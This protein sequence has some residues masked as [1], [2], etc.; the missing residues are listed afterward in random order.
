MQIPFR[1][2]RTFACFRLALFC[3]EMVRAALIVEL[4]VPTIGLSDA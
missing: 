2:K 4:G 3:T 1:A